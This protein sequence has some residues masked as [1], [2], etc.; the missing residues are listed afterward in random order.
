MTRM[1]HK[2]VLHALGMSAPGAPDMFLALAPIRNALATELAEARAALE[3]STRSHALTRWSHTNAVQGAIDMALGLRY[4]HKEAFPGYMLL[5]R[6]LKPRNV[7]VM[8]AI[9]APTALF[10]YVATPFLP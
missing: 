8:E 6:D 1:N 10:P 7:G 9:K 3:S 5:H 2:N 4:L